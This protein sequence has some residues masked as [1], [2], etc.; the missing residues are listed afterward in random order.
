MRQLSLDPSSAAITL[1]D[2]PIPGTLRGGVQVRTAYSL[3]STGTEL[4][5]VDLASK[6]LL[7]K[8]RD[9]PD[10]V[11]KVLDAARTDGIVATIKKVRE[12]LAS[13]QPLGYSLAGTVVAVGEECESLRVGMLVACGG[14]TACHAEMVSVPENLTVRIPEGVPFQDAAFATVASVAL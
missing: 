4:S 1:S 6:S 14:A 3:I 13:P 12:R 11:A 9:R 10:Q 8:A 2:V 7:E 5:K